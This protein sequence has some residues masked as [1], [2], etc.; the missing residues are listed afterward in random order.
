MVEYHN[1]VFKRIS[2]PDGNSP[3]SLQGLAIWE[4]TPR[5]QLAI[6][7]ESYIVKY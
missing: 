4:K 1:T 3:T 6:H 7:L 2:V 5:A